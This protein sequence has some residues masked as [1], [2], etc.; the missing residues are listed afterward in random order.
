MFTD[1]RGTVHAQ[2]N[3]KGKKN[4]YVVQQLCI[5]LANIELNSCSQVSAVF[6]PCGV[7]SAQVL[8][9]K[10]QWLWRPGNKATY[11]CTL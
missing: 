3:L 7:M 2:A 1:S 10:Q 11:G 9:H 4:T 5:V 6:V 8:Y